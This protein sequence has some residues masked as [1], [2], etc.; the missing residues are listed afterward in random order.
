[1]AAWLWLRVSVAASIIAVTIPEILAA[2]RISQACE[3]PIPIQTVEPVVSP[4]VDAG[5]P[6]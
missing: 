6:S 2:P 1:M 5:P 3:G 4:L